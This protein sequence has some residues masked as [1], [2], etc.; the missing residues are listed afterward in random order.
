MNFSA[1]KNRGF[2]LVE[3]LVVLAIFGV[4]VGAVYSLYVTSLKGSSKHDESQ[5]VQQNLRLAMDSVTRDL[6]G[7]GLL[8]PS[9]T[10]PIAPS[11]LNNYSTSL[12]INMVSSM[13]KMATIRRNNIQSAEFLNFST[14]VEPP[15]SIDGFQV[16][17][18][19]TLYRPSTYKYTTL[20]NGVGP[21]YIVKKISRGDM[22][23]YPPIYPV[24]ALEIGSADPLPS[25]FF[26][27]PG[28]I[29]TGTSATN[30]VANNVTY[31][32]VT[33]AD[34]SNCP[35]GQRCLARSFNNVPLNQSQIIAGKLTSISF[36]YLYD[37]GNHDNNPYSYS[38]KVS[39]VR[40]I[41]VTITGITNSTNWGNP[42][43]MQMTTV[44]ML[45]NRR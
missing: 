42:K 5:D 33:N 45:R 10:D 8:V 38:D 41:R 12:S 11:A 36:S 26:V 1:Y 29:I 32:I 37:T 14:S 34:N 21:Y 4:V 6:Q 31:S 25:T 43:T 28:D 22:S 44:V 24:M 39:S 35:I 23:K 15:S 9:G 16:N 2:T 3:I 40:A 13:S 20:I 18:T 30:N 17:D 27:Q 19:V 7:M